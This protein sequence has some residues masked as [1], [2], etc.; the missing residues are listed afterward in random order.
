MYWCPDEHRSELRI[1]FESGFLEGNVWF[2]QDP[3]S[4]ISAQDWYDLEM[5]LQHL[6]DGLHMLSHDHQIVVRRRRRRRCLWHFITDVSDMGT[7]ES[8][9]GISLAEKLPLIE[10]PDFSDQ[11]YK[12]CSWNQI[13]YI[14]G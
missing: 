13:Q 3:E 4:L 11:R 12:L 1:R 10:K 14:R 6:D 5:L 7:E 8:G 9:L 2:P